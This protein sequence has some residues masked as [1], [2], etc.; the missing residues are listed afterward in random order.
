MSLEGLS[1]IP[2]ESGNEMFDPWLEDLWGKYDFKGNPPK[3][4]SKAEERLRKT[5]EEYAR[6]LGDSYSYASSSVDKKKESDTRKRQ[7]HNE[8]AIMVMG[9][10][11]S[12]MVS[13]LAEHIANFAYEYVNGFTIEE[14]EKYRN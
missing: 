4:G 1:S 11:R 5:C 2:A 8:I 12:G 7:L 9:K 14:K 13:S 6:F 3:I 10:Q